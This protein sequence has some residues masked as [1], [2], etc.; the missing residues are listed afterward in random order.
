MS[1]A[2]VQGVALAPRGIVRTIGRPVVRVALLIPL[3]GS[4]GLFGPSCELCSQLAAEELNVG[5]GI[6]G[7]EVE[8]V[9]VDGSGPPAE[10][11]AEVALL[12]KLG[13]VDAVVGWHIS[14]VRRELVPLI[15]GR[16]PYVYTALYEGGE[17][18]PGVFLTGEVPSHQLA[19][20]IK[21]QAAENGVKRWYIVGN[22]YIWPRQSAAAAAGYA[23]STGGE[24]CGQTFVPLGTTSFEQ[25]LPAI[26]R[27]RADAVLLLLVGDDSV[28]FNRSFAAFELD[29]ECIRFSPLME[30]NMLLATGQGATKGLYA[31]AGYFESLV[32]PESL[33]F[34]ARY[35]RRFG[36]NAPPLN[37]LGESC[38]E[39]INLLAAL[40]TK[41]GSLD[42]RALDMAAAGHVEYHGPRGTLRVRNRHVDQRVYLAEP[43]GFDL[44]VTTEL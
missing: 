29:S 40:A 31:A 16:V 39:G 37:S 15:A 3:H 11:A 23:V 36:L 12:V 8:L 42:V 21:W 4:A 7:R 34:S 38:Y 26:E 17:Q 35:T 32:T 20:A 5:T 28:R 9:V 14:A 24:V 27:S 2:R 13:A 30:E 1:E 10:V 22:D 19:P 44:V 33:D 41:A 25:V 6:L 18:S 43:D